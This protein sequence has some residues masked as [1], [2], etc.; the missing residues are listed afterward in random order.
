MIAVNL[1]DGR[2]LQFPDGTDKATMKQ[3]IDS[4][5]M[6]ERADAAK[7][8]TLQLQPGSAE[9][10]A[11]M[12]E[13]AMKAMDVQNLPPQDQ[14]ARLLF[15]SGNKPWSQIGLEQLA[16]T[17]AGLTRGAA[18]LIG[19]PGTAMDLINAGMGKVGILDKPATPSPFSGAAIQ[20][21]LNDLT[22][23]YVNY[24]APGVAGDILGTGGE[25]LG[26]GAGGKLAA[27]GALGATALGYMTEGTPIEPY[28]KFVGT[29]GGGFAANGVTGLVTAVKNNKA[30]RSFIE[31][32][33]SVIELKSQAG[34][35]YNA[36][37]ASGAMADPAQ[38]D[39]F[40]N[41]LMT[42]L[43]D[44]GMITPKG[45]MAGSYP[46]ISDAIN[47]ID[48]YRGSPMT[49]TEMLQVRKSFQA[50]ARS[51]DPVEAR[52]GTMMIRQFDDFT[53]P[54]APQIAEANKI[55][56]DAMQGDL[57]EKTIELAGSK[58]GQFTGS[59]FENALRTEFRALERKIIK[60]QLTATPDESA[61]ITRISQGGF[62][63]NLARDIGKAAPR[64][65]VS[66]GLS[67]GVP[68]SIG[69]AIGGPVLGAAFS[70]ATLGAG[71]LGRRVATGLQTRNAGLLSA[72]TR[73]GGKMPAE[74]AAG[75]S[76]LPEI[77]RI[78][79]GL[80][81]QTNTPENR[82]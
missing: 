34:G 40:A 43:K 18:G 24:E 49:P 35:L 78:A 48:D 59:G 42:T 33:P 36:A 41:G 26:G 29:L 54:I 45:K 37:R 56:R 8:G 66:T 7:A 2:V 10:V 61:L 13:M 60:G 82:R 72:I 46:K 30:I 27:G 52:L 17:G 51:S 81:A 25:L 22:G 50:A 19:L 38:V 44:E 16:G 80:L 39:D 1:P 62:A 76:T 28:A 69:N 9:R 55:Y 68:F 67:A 20:S 11:A 73:S 58:A 75:K 79:P 64:G 23:G 63:E 21:A 31:K 65:I 74:L 47:L 3:A 5:I 14:T 77:I 32:Q 12:N 15:G 57:I 71:E 6:R 4:L 53:S 70:A